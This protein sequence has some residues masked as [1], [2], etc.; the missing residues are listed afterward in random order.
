[1]NS[2]EFFNVNRNTKTKPKIVNQTYIDITNKLDKDKE[3]TEEEK[4]FCNFS[5]REILQCKGNL[6]E[7]KIFAQNIARKNGITW[8]YFYTCLNKWYKKTTNKTLKME[9]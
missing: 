1:M 5:F 4:N 2:N 6:E 9:R 8:N 3:L 7:R